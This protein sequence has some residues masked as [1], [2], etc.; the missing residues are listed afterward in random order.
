M[1]TQ[2]G[3]TDTYGEHCVFNFYDFL[4]FFNIEYTGKRDRKI[5]DVLRGSAYTSENDVSSRYVVPVQCEKILQ[6]CIAPPDTFFGN[7]IMLRVSAKE[8][9]LIVVQNMQKDWDFLSA[10]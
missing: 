4:A 6:A 1:R 9:Q 7:Y 8:T 2:N 5:V 3:W 10:L